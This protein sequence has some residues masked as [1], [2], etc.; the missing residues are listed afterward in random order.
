MR[1]PFTAAPGIDVLPSA[2]ELPNL[3]SL[4]VNAF[5]LHGAEPVLVDAG[6]VA[7]R[8]EF[9]TALR[10]V[11][12]PADLRWL[13]LTHTD[14]DHIG[15]IAALL[16]ENPHIRVVTSFG[17][18]G[19]M[20]LFDPLPMDRVHLINPGQTLVLSDRTLTAIRPPSFDNPITTGFHD[21]RTNA[22]F[23][24]DCFGALLAEIPED[25]AEL[26]EDELRSGQVRWTTIDSSWLHKVDTDVL[27]RDLDQIRG[28]EPSI[29][30][31]S[32]L[33]PA[34][35][36]LLELCLGSIAEVPGAEPFEGPDQAALEQMLAAMAA[37]APA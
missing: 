30:L 12:D 1:A 36:R 21:D 29:V 31:S 5:V 33:P 19:I 17:G 22:L 4:V 16:A 6:I 20:G 32:H 35:G 26:S 23:S 24:S 25:A 34:P 37:P 9:L 8:D 18:V 10:T 2:V 11:I 13:W 7:E 3:G 27:A 28:I 15:A 14:F